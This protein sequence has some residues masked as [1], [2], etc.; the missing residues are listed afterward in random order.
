[1]EGGENQD[2]EIRHARDTATL[3]PFRQN[4]P[5]S[6]LRPSV[7]IVIVNWNAGDYL[8]RCLESIPPARTGDF[9]LKR[10]VV[11]DNASSDGSTEMKEIPG[12][13]LVIIRNDENKG[14]AAAC[15]QGAA[16]SAADYILFLNPDTQLLPESLTR[17][18]RFMESSTHS[19]VGICGVKLLDEDGG[20]ATACAR[21][22][23]L[24]I[25]V[26]Q[27]F[28]LSR[29]FPE[30]F[31][32]HFIPAEELFHSMEVDQ[33]I[34]AFFLIRKDLFVTLNGF[35]ERFFVY[36]EEVDF[37]LR[38]KRVGYASYFLADV[39]AMHIGRISSRQASMMTLYYSL[40]SRLKYALK[41]FQRWE[42]V[43]LII[44]T[45]TLEFVSRILWAFFG[46]SVAS[47]GDVLLAYKRLFVSFF[48]VDTYAIS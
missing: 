37:S 33:I 4:A 38:A 15:N 32:C 19:G 2:G 5:M 1:M 21:F 17:P 27:M 47:V 31:P 9:E 45:F 24:A 35:D 30:I 6:R 42:A 3:L 41:H 39:T 29:L 23:S 44:L 48:P 7:D 8:R 34:G 25:Y 40:S 22:P 36:F 16:G 28:G 11:V 18:I 13:S 46:S 43:L 12:L 10:I 26:S 14:F 20:I